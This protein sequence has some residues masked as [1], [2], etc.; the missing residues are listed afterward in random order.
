[1]EKVA[2]RAF[3]TIEEMCKTCL[4]TKFIQAEDV[5]ERKNRENSAHKFL[6]IVSVHFFKLIFNMREKSK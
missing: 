5:D 1:V 2:A 3:E 6:F 4:K